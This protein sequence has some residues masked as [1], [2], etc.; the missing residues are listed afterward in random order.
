MEKYIL[1]ARKSTDT[2]DKQV[3]SIEAQLVELR[4]FAK[5]NDL[6]V[7][8]ELIEKRTAKM[9][10]RPVFN[11]MIKRIE[12]GEANGILA[13]HPDRLARNSIDGGQIIYLL[14]QT[15]LNYLQFPIFQ[16]ENTSQG[17][18]M[19][20]I[21]FGQSKYYVDNLSEN[22]KRGL[23]AKVRNGNFPSQAPFGYLND[24]RT[25][26]II[27]DKR[28]APLVKEIF[29]KYARGDQTMSQLADFLQGNGVITRTGKVFKDDKV[30]SILQN[31]FYYGH[32]LY[33]GEL[34]EG[35]HQPI[36]SKAL[37][38]KVQLVIAERG[39]KKRAKKEAVPFLGLM[40][41]ANCGM[42]ITSE[43]KT[44][45]QKNGNF[46][47][48]TYYRCSR[49]KRAVKCINPPIREKD[50]LLQ[51]SALLG[52]YTMSEKMFAFMNERIEQ[53]EQA[54]VAGNVSLLDDLRTQIAKLTNKQQILLDSYLD[55]DIDRQTFLTKK[56][57]ILSQKKRLEESLVNLQV[58]QNAWI[59]PMKKW[60]E[61]AK[62]ICYLLESDDF[63]GQKAVLLEIFGSNLF[64]HNKTVT[65]TLTGVS[66][67]TT[68]R[69]GAESGFC[70]WQELRNVNE[71]VALLSDDS[72]K[73]RILVRLGTL[74]TNNWASLLRFRQQLRE[75][76]LDTT[77]DNKNISTASSSESTNST[78]GD[79]VTDGSEP[80]TGNP[81]TA[82]EISSRTVAHQI[83]HAKNRPLPP[84][85][86]AA[87]RQQAN[88][89]LGAR[90]VA[91]RCGIHENT[92]RAIW[93]E[94]PRP[95]QRGLHRFTEE[96][97]QRAE[98]LLAQGRTLIEIGLELGFDRGT[99]RKHLGYRANQQGPN[100][101]T[102]L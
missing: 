24:S 69:K 19:L 70:L 26:T 29:E 22:T 17:K 7:I 34:Y 15:T 46:H 25:K 99:V 98:A 95:K 80:A 62:S 23:R 79:T 39:H 81:G 30:K 73:I 5:D 50:L 10:G 89:G 14:D 64:L 56:S 47:R 60:L 43:T 86:R 31:P 8:D 41:C 74:N 91:R 67:K 28:Y 32:F 65:Q 61:T 66:S 49:K 77:T 27:L 3:L 9:P 90:E 52:K 97:R 51:P 100:E 88:S 71:K 96:D 35:R 82:H 48:W 4:K 85:T 83:I 101:T 13:W 59:E 21:M 75:T 36:F 102:M 92:V 33:K 94:R 55:Q 1:Y 37:F 42:S 12:N 68:F 78:G 84:E 93:R 38:D 2:E 18:F 58:N 72:E 87:I 16:F 53:D 57:K 6:V 54:E 63:D 11:S 45:T 40:K 20:S 76:D 44:R